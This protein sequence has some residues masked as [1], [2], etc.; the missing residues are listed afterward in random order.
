MIVVKILASLASNRSGASA[1]EYALIIALVGGAI[2][3]SVTAL[4]PTIAGVFKATTTQV[5][6]ETS[7]IG[8]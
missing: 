6:A 7:V 3:V 5:A 8:K 2:I 4:G 1:A